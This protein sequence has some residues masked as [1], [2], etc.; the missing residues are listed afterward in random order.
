MEI[1][2]IN[3]LAKAFAGDAKFSE[4]LDLA[5]KAVNIYHSE[6]TMR[7]GVPVKIKTKGGDC[8]RLR[9]MLDKADDKAQWTC[10]LIGGKGELVRVIQ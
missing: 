6:L 9:H 8:V 1:E 5:S 10:V 2:A 3:K 7:D 4:A